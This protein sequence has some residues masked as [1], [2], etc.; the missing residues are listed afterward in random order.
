MSMKQRG[1]KCLHWCFIYSIEILILEKSTFF[2]H[3]FVVSI[4][5]VFTC[6]FVFQVGKIS[7]NRDAFPVPVPLSLILI[8]VTRAAKLHSMTWGKIAYVHVSKALTVFGCLDYL[9][10]KVLLLCENL[11]YAIL[12]SGNLLSLLNIACN[13][14]S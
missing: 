11:F 12:Q 3:Y 14:Y 10:L 6:S 2:L 5:G 13:A 7:G 9:H 4:V 8:S 1:Y